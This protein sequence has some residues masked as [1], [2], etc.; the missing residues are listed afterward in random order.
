MNLNSYVEWFINNVLKHPKYKTPLSLPLLNIDRLTW[1]L[2]LNET[3]ERKRIKQF[4][5][6][7][8]IWFNYKLK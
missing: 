8:K 5:V 6:L 2:D 4:I 3:M 7:W 1:K